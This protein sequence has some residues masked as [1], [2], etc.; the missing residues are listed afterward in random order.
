MSRI[1]PNPWLAIDIGHGADGAGA[2]A[3]L[4]LGALPRRARA[5]TTRRRRPELVRGPIADSWRRSF[6]AGVDPSR[7][8][9]RAR[10]RR[11]GRD[12]RAAG[13]SIRSAAPAPLIR[14]CLAATAEEAGYLIVVSDANGMLLR[15]RAQ[16][17]VRMRAAE[18]MNFA[19][20]T[21][22]SE[23][24]A[25]T[26]AI[27]TA[28]A[29]D[30][31]VQVF[32]ARALQ[33]GRPALDVLG[34]A[35][36]RPRHRRAARRHRPHGRL[37]DRPPAEPRGGHRDRA[38]RRGVAA[39]TLQERD[40]RLRARY[41][42]PRRAPGDRARSSRRPGAPIT[43]LPATGARRAARAPAGRRRAR[44]ALGRP[45]VAEPVGPHARGFVVHAVER[46]RPT[47]AARPLLRLTL[48]GRD[49]APLE[50]DGRRD[51]A[52][53]PP[54]RDPRPAVRAPRRA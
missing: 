21:L 17:R 2:G 45:A 26:N 31:A 40:A 33:R 8:A 12:A 22:W 14:E 30:H 34:G 28:L 48:L 39:L 54:R 4:R 24:G 6:A 36:P 50:I 9:P 13:R 27:G 42:E 44:A 16:A 11:R 51:R 43:R 37:L 46:A 5:T 25:G 19:E 7:P 41:G 47:R 38:G 35:D 53:P 3:A 23:P 49:R 29:A 15:S 52:A 1:S 20:G 32:G 18:V 10:R